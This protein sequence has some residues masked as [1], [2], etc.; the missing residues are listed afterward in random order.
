MHDLFDMSVIFWRY[1]APMK[2]KTIVPALLYNS[3]VANR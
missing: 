3:T 1:D 2:I